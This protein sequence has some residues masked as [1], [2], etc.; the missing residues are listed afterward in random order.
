MCQRPLSRVGGPGEHSLVSQGAVADMAWYMG[1]TTS[2]REILP[3]MVIFGMVASFDVLIIDKQ[4]VAT[5]IDLGAQVLS[6]SAQLCEDLTL[7]VQ[8]LGW[9]L[10]IE[11]MGGCS[12]AIPQIC[13]GKP[14]DSRDKRLQ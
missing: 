3:R 10:E 11:G 9:L 1:P 8:P 13:G 7:H 2:V 4:E 5:L 6:A 12:H 14:P